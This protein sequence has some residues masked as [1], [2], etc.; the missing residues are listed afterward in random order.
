VARIFL[1]PLSSFDPSESPV[2]K[3][4][5]LA[6]HCRARSSLERAFSDPRSAI[7]LCGRAKAGDWC[8]ASR[9]PLRL[10]AES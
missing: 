7:N 9:M 10:I 5:A 1:A 8:R 4:P 6:V 3:V 2:E